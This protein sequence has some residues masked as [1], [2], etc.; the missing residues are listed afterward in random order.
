MKFYE[1]KLKLSGDGQKSSTIAGPSPGYYP[2]GNQEKI[3][4]DKFINEEKF[5]FDNLIFKGGKRARITDFIWHSA[6]SGLGYVIS[7]RIKTAL[8]DFNLPDHKFYKLPIYRDSRGNQYQY[9]KLHMLQYSFDYSLIDFE[10]STFYFGDFF[11]ENRV[12]TKYKNGEELTER[13]KNLDDLE[14]K[15]WGNELVMNNKFLELSLDCFHVHHL[16]TDFI[17]SKRLKK[18]LENMN[19]TGIEFKD[20]IFVTKRATAN[21]E[22]W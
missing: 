19:A 1:L 18:S 5:V 7:E 12:I 10:K 16:S 20:S 6:I 15:I 2:N 8:N 22:L 11:K 13:L 9:Y 17:I 4:L 21:K 3:T 14:E